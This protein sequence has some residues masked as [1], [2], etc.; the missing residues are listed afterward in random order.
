M[1]SDLAL[2]AMKVELIT[3]EFGIFQEFDE[4]LIVFKYGLGDRIDP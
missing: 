3:V 1:A 2:I 4:I